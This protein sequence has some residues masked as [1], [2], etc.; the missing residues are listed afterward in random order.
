MSDTDSK[1]TL[2]LSIKKTPETTTGRP[3]KSLASGA[4]A[5]RKARQALEEQKQT[6]APLA[7]R[8]G[9]RTRT[10]AR[11]DAR[12][13]FQRRDRPHTR[14]EQSPRR[15]GP[16]HSGTRQRPDRTST[17]PTPQTF[18]P[19]AG[20]HKAF[21][22]CPRGLEAVLEEELIQI[23]LDR[24]QAASGG[25]QFETDWPGVQK[26]NLWSRIATRILVQV[27]HAPVRYES[28]ITRLTLATPWENWFGPDHTLRVDTSA[29]RSP[30]KSLQFCNLLVKDGICDRLRDREGARPSIDTVRP[31]A[32][33]HLFLSETTATLYLDTSG[34]S[35]FKRGWRFNKG[36]API[37]ENLAAGLLALAGWTPE[38]PLLDPFCGSGTILVEAAWQALNVAPGINRPFAFERL[39][40]HDHAQWQTMRQEA[41]EAILTPQDIPHVQISGYEL[42]V[43]SLDNA[44]R[45]LKRA[46]VPDGLIRLKQA[47]AC[48]EPA[49][50]ASGLILTNPP[51]GIR[52]ETEDTLMTD[53][54]AQLKQHF[55]GW[56]IGVISADLDLPRNLRLKAKRRIPVFNGALDCRLFMFDLVSG[57]YRN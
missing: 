8:S 47:N 49:P 36:E 31:D 9:G 3:K 20:R 14:S 54:A 45:N 11:D 1:K 25:V 40:H 5:H 42:D 13:G 16:P 43:T 48:R 33:V 10:G 4:R 38:V 2:R 28:D 22:S 30:M 37:R 55:S 39:R 50:G 12:T 24:V 26:A 56:T 27:A 35:L 57:Q 18:N 15:N 41:T 32:R 17:R 52:L 19:Y 29:I 23:G 7:E 44:R 34:E 53:W 46:H 21:A 6:P 51:Y